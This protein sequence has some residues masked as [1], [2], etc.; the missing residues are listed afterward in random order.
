LRYFSGF[1]PVY[2]LPVKV[3]VKTSQEQYCDTFLD[4]SQLTH[5]RLEFLVVR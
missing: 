1:W 5:F 3:K 2:L 4:F